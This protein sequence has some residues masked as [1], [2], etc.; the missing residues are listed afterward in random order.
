VVELDTEVVPGDLPHDTLLFDFNDREVPGYVWDFPTL[1][2]GR[3][4]M[5][6]GAY[7]VGGD[8]LGP[9]DVLARHLGRKGLD[10]GRYRLKPFAERG[11]DRSEPIARPHLLLVGEAAGIDLATGEGI[12]QA[13]AFGALAARY[14]ADCFGKGD[15]RFQDQDWSALVHAAREG[16]LVRHR[17]FVGRYLYSSE[18]P[19]IERLGQLNPALLEIGVRRFAGKPTP[20]SLALKAAAAALRWSLTGGALALARAKGLVDGL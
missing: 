10:I 20:T 9:R 18:R 1:V 14:L 19:R 17:H 6:R 13:L 7:L 11:L 8:D 5:C 16:R 15:L 12:P 2:E 4:L 3:P